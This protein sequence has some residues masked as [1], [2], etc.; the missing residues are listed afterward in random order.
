MTC[1]P[2]FSRVNPDTVGYVWTG[3]FNFNMLRVAKEKVAESKIS[4]YMWTGPE[5]QT[6][7]ME[8]MKYTDRIGTELRQK[9]WSTLTAFSQFTFNNAT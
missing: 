4:G 6:R 5:R 8:F 9:L 7:M 2:S 1:R 3:E